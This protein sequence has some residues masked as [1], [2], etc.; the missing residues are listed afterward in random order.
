[1]DIAKH[2]GY[3]IAVVFGGL[4]GCKSRADVKRSRARRLFA[5]EVQHPFTGSIVTLGMKIEPGRIGTRNIQ[6]QLPEIKPNIAIIPLTGL[7]GES[8][9]RVVASLVKQGAHDA[10]C[11]FPARRFSQSCPSLLQ[12]VRQA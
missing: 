3:A 1:M 11:Q 8:G 9:D 2:P 7:A 10:A 4:V 5:G 12:H 6:R